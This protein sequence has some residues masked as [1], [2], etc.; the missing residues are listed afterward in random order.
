M[1]KVI[2]DKKTIGFLE[3]EVIKQQLVPNVLSDIG[4]N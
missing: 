2:C 4:A 3:N 1:I